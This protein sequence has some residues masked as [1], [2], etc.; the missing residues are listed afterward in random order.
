MEFQVVYL[1][2][3]VLRMSNVQVFNLLQH[4]VL[5]YNSNNN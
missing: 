3:F 1:L 2:I 5:D 4:I